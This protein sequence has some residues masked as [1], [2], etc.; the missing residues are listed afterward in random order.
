MG[1]FYMVEIYQ[2]ARQ[3]KGD[4]AVFT[5]PGGGESKR[6]QLGKDNNSESARII[7]RGPF[8]PSLIPLGGGALSH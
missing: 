8:P 3:S 5:A 4:L 2:P 1:L 7:L 6:S